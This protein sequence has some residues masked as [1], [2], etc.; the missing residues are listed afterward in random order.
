MPSLPPGRLTF[1]QIRNFALRKAG[2]RAVID[3]ANIWLTQLLFELYV[4]WEWPFLMAVSSMQLTGPTFPLPTTPGEFL[5]AQDDNAFN[6][7]TFDGQPINPPQ[8]IVS[9]TDP[10][11][12]ATTVVQQASGGMPRIWTA[13]RGAGIGRV[14]PDPTGHVAAATLRFKFLPIAD[15]TP[16]TTPTAMDG[17]VPVFPYHLFLV[18]ALYVL[19]LEYEQ[20]PRASDERQKVVQQLAAI[21][22]TAMPLRSQPGVIPLDPEVFGT[23]FTE[24][25]SSERG[26]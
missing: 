23:P 25:L 1:G 17:L 16:P 20:D 24:D 5:Q 14:Y 4:E 3:D 8:S 10:A 22:G 15:T 26:Q 2:N 7:V 9:E 12:F 11:T 13:D 21:R 6:V 19:A 18:Q